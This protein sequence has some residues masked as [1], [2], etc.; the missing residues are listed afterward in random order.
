MTRMGAIM[1]AGLLD[2]GGRN[3]AISCRTR[4]GH[5]RRGAVVGLALFTQYWYWHPLAYCV[6]LA[7]QPT[8]VIGVDATLR[9]PRDFQAR[10]WGVLGLPGTQRVK[11]LPGT[12]GLGG[13]G[14]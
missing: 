11:R 6:S 12:R 3:M 9:A 13:A 2:A 4:S 7:L 10:G 14:G 8:A 5:Y 1:A